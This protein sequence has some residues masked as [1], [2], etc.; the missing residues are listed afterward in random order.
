MKL[1]KKMFSLLL[2]A[3]MVFSVITATPVFADDDNNYVCYIGETGYT[4]LGAAIGVASAS[5]PAVDG[6]V[7]TLVADTVETSRIYAYTSVTITDDGN[8]HTIYLANTASNTYGRGLQVGNS[9][10][11]SITATAPG[12]ITVDCSGNR[13]VGLFV[14]KGTLNLSGLTIKN[15]D[16]SMTGE[17]T[18]LG[19]AVRVGYVSGTTNVSGT[20]NI[21]NCTFE[22]NSNTTGSAIYIS[23]S[24]TCNVNGIDTTNGGG[25]IYMDENSSFNTSGTNY[26]TKITNLL[27]TVTLG[28][29]DF[30][31]RLETDHAINAA[32]SFSA[33]SDVYLYID[34]NSALTPGDVVV[35]S[36]SIS[37]VFGC[38]T[39]VNLQAAVYLDGT[40]NMF[41]YAGFACKIGDTLYS[42]L[43]EAVTAASAGSTIIILDN[44]EVTEQLNIAKNLT[45]MDD[46]RPHTIYF[47]NTSSSGTVPGRGISKTGSGSTLYIRGSRLGRLT[48]AGHS[49]DG[50]AKN[51]GPLIYNSGSTVYLSKVILTENDCANNG[52]ALY[53]SGSSKIYTD[54]SVIR[55]NSAQRGGAVYLYSSTAQ[56]YLRD[57]T[58]IT[59][60]TS[61]YRGGC[62][63]V[64]SLNNGKIYLSG[65]LN[66]T[67][68]Y[69]GDAIRNISVKDASALILNGN[70]SGSVGVDY[71]AVAMSGKV[72]GTAAKSTYTGAGCIYSDLYPTLKGHIDSD[73]NSL[74]WAVGEY[75][76]N[77]GNASESG[78][79]YTYHT[80]S[81]TLSDGAAQGFALSVN[82]GSFTVDWSDVTAPVSE[83]YA[84]DTDYEYHVFSD[85]SQAVGNYML[86]SVRFSGGCGASAIQ[87]LISAATFTVAADGL[88][89]QASMG[90]CYS[91]GASEI[92]VPG[93]VMGYDPGEYSKTYSE[94]VVSTSGRYIAS[95]KDRQTNALVSEFFGGNAGWIGLVRQSSAWYWEEGA[96]GGT[97]VS[98]NASSDQGYGSA[99]ANWAAGHPSRSNTAAYMGEDGKWYSEDLSESL[100]CYTAYDDESAYSV[101]HSISAVTTSSILSSM[102]LSFD[103]DISMY[104][105][106]GFDAS[107]LAD[108]DN[109]V[110]VTAGSGESSIVT[111]STVSQ[112]SGLRDTAGNYGIKVSLPAKMMGARI[113]IELCE[114]DGTVVRGFANYSGKTPS[115]NYNPLF[116][117]NYI[118]GGEYDRYNAS[119]SKS[120]ENMV[121]AMLNYGAAA[122]QQF[123]YDTDS[124]VNA[125]YEDNSAVTQPS[126]II[127]AA[128]VY[129]GSGVTWQT[130]SLTADSLTVMRFSFTATSSVTGASVDG[131]SVVVGG[132]GGSYYIDIPVAAWQLSHIYEI[133]VTTASGAAVMKVC[134][135][136]VLK[137]I[138]SA[139]ADADAVK[140]ADSL[141]KFGKA[142]DSY[143]GVYYESHSAQEAVVS[144][145]YAFLTKEAYTQYDQYQISAYASRRE[146]DADPERTGPDHYT[147]L[148][149]SSFVYNVYRNVYGVDVTG[150]FTT[151]S[152]ATFSTYYLTNYPNSAS[153]VRSW[154]TGVP[155]TWYKS[156]DYTTY[157]NIW[158]SV[159]AEAKSIMQPG[160]AIVYY[161]NNQSGK[162]GGHVVIWT[163]TGAIHATGSDYSYSSMTDGWDAAGSVHYIP[164]ADFDYSY[165]MGHG[166]SKVVVVRASQVLGETISD[167]GVSRSQLGCLSIDAGLYNSGG[168]RIVTGQ[169]VCNSDSVSV[170]IALDNGKMLGIMNTERTVN[171][172]YTAPSQ[173]SV[174][175][176]NAG[177]VVSG[178]T[179]TWK[180]VT[181]AA[182]AKVTLTIN[183]TVSGSA[184][185]YIGKGSGTV[186]S[187]LA[188]GEAVSLSFDRRDIFIENSVSSTTNTKIGNLSSTYSNYSYNTSTGDGITVV[189]SILSTVGART[190]SLGSS[191]LALR[192][193]LFT[194]R[195]TTTSGGYRSFSIKIS[196]KTDNA[197]LV[198]NF[199]GGYGVTNG[200]NHFNKENRVRYMLPENLRKGDVIMMYDSA[201]DIYDY[202]IYLASSSASSNMMKISGS[203]GKSS[204]VS[205]E[206]VLQE[207]LYY[208][209][210]FAVLRPVSR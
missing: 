143:Y 47:A 29:T 36:S 53:M 18:S 190:T 65:N 87:S 149:C 160:D 158:R 92:Y 51:Y 135:N 136:Y 123:G 180:N 170:R 154:N 74:Y 176:A 178:S 110:R 183:A 133:S 39:I 109:Y 12:N 1:S 71:T 17:Y 186:S 69:K 152:S 6:D 140:T 208:T 169:G 34:E 128:P 198:D 195:N 19:G 62:G 166:A 147:F 46:G 49:M 120:F 210:L 97:A 84:V 137:E 108:G 16:N 68:N 193:T 33:S 165:L 153:V 103:G 196:K 13:G 182:G 32:S 203:T 207:A 187:A 127:A 205:A 98:G 107:F 112:M 141:Y 142:A 125:S 177:G 172:T 162:A 131:D 194:D 113:S 52:G 11:V 63:A 66:I 106:F 155:G 104:Y 138:I 96:L 146:L 54:N 37:S 99:F 26:I 151:H 174:T 75:S 80:P 185:S 72:F 159:L 9:K 202:Y 31:T 2:S 111:Q 7:I 197:L 148:D 27:G 209:R 121:K 85:A 42:S 206:A 81:V 45:I 24:S 93:T 30:I 20:A 56:L 124:L 132:S 4:S 122:Q 139:N 44:C 90:V 181:V 3:A 35:N 25:D 60:N 21:T 134:G 82:N 129:S 22:S 117:A 201:N 94:T 5:G 192:N 89:Q 164:E 150:A 119:Y 8:P 200:S 83:V 67:G 161:G 144:T 38:F 23:R 199:L 40:L 179:V 95:I 77:A 50:T 126:A 105:Y 167:Y 114:A 188:G 171:V 175:G 102:D 78:H 61:T 101:T 204:L 189:N 28:G 88:P 130:A 163:G 43:T 41:D 73:A 70:I 48:L 15:S 118:F 55:N 191:S 76:V 116:Y 10:T 115:K 59:N 145:A 100:G 57:G 156:S 86:I 91:L 173:L 58:V 79:T 184:G 64:Y 168:S 14:Y 157:I